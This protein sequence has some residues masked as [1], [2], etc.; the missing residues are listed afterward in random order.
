[1]IHLAKERPEL[2]VVSDQVGVPTYAPDLA[3]WS[4]QA[5]QSEIRPTP[6]G[7]YNLCPHGETTWYDFANTIFSHFQELG[8]PL[9][10]HEVHPIASEDY[11]TPATRPKNSRLNT[12][13]FEQTFG[14]SLTSWQDGVED[15]VKTF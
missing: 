4:V 13:K 15:C 7:I 12:N 2:K 8:V 1:M 3:R 6:Y 5:V 14:I 9:M 11:P 10:I